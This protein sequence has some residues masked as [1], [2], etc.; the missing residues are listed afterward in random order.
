[1]E[2]L[3]VDAVGVD[4]LL[5]PVGREQDH[6]VA[7]P[8]AAHVRAQ[9]LVRDL[10]PEHRLRRVAH[11]GDDHLAGVDDGAVEVEEHD[12]KA[13]GARVVTAQVAQSH[14]HSGPRR[15]KALR[16]PKLRAARTT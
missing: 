2:R 6:L 3:V 4:E 7:Q 1:M 8:G 11:R 9:L 12:R 10:E 14:K 5:D 16:K 13:H 15:A